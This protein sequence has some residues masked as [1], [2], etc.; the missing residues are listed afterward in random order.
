MAGKRKPKKLKEQREDLAKPSKWRLQHGGFSAPIREADPET[1]SPIEH[2]RAVDT[3]P[4]SR[5]ALPIRWPPA[6]GP[7]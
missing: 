6:A 5:E 3:L 7:A 4:L 1:G 2:R